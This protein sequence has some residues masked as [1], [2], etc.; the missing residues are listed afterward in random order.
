MKVS[1]TVPV[2]GTGVERELRFGAP[3]CPMT[4]IAAEF[5]A[6]ARQAQVIGRI[7]RRNAVDGETRETRR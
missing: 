4:R 6:A 5:P 2:G 1:F 3:E 7:G